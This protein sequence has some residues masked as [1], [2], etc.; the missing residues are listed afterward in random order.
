LKT[1]IGTSLADIKKPGFIRGLRAGR[2]SNLDAILLILNRISTAAFFVETMQQQLVRAIYNT[3]DSTSS[4][5]L[6]RRKLVHWQQ[7]RETLLAIS[8]SFNFIFNACPT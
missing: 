6:I 2:V 1:Y 4:C 8:I 7:F 3:I 5:R